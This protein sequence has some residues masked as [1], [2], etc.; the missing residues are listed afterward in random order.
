MASAPSRIVVLGS[1]I[2]TT[3]VLSRRQFDALRAD[4]A[5]AY[6]AIR[7]ISAWVSATSFAVSARAGI[8]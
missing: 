6:E 3:A 5:S 8:S 2:Q 7:R 4:R 1:R